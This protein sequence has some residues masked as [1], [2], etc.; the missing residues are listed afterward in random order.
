MRNPTS[1]FFL[2]AVVF[3]TAIFLSAQSPK[4]T[5]TFQKVEVIETNASNGAVIYDLE[6]NSTVG[7]E[8]LIA[9]SKG[10]RTEFIQDGTFW[11]LGS[12]S[13]GRWLNPNHFWLHSGSLLYCSEN[14]REITFSTITSTASYNGSGTLIIEATKN[15]GFKFI[16]LEAKGKI[17]TAKGGIKEVVGGRMLLIIGEPTYYGDAY[18][19]DIML[20]VRSSRLINAFPP[21]FRLLNK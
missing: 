19:I 15:G 9:T 16:P 2:I 10:S 7:S 4:A 13:V 12:M 6:I 3:T 14:D 17:S 8:H 11:R 1:I 21:L 5:Y 20:M 18:D